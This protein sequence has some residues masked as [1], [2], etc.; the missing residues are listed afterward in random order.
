MNNVQTTINYMPQLISVVGTISGVILGW[1]LSYCS[2][3]VGG[4]K[5]FSD[6][7]VC[8]KSKSDEYAYISKLFIHNTSH[9]Y[10]YMRDLNILFCDSKK[11]ELICSKPFKGICTFDNIGSNT[12]NKDTINSVSLTGQDSIEL[13]LSDIVQNSTEWNKITKVYLSYKYKKKTKKIL[14]IKNFISSNV[15]ESSY[16]KFP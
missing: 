6:S 12:Q 4:I 11:Q 2:G 7:F 8:Q 13:I 15:K 1:V 14:I 16:N 9:Q 5:A 3:H 10:K